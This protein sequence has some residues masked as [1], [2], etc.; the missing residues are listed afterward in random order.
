MKRI[1]RRLLAVIRREGMSRD[2]EAELRAHVEMEAESLR[3]QGMDAAAARRRAGATLGGWDATVEAVRETHGLPRTEAVL[4]E[5]RQAGR[6]LRRTPGFTASAV[7]VLA[8]G[9]GG[10]TAAYGIARAVLLEPLPY[11]DES[12]MVSVYEADSSGARRIPS[13]PTVREWAGGAGSFEAIAY[14]RGET[15]PVRSDEG[16]L[17]LLAAYATDD[18]FR[19]MRV[20][21]ALGRVF[22]EAESSAG[23]AV[24]VLSWHVWRD[25]YGGD[26]AVVGRSLSTAAGPFTVVGVMPEGVRY[27]AWADLWL[28]Q[29][30]LSAAGRAAI[31]RRDLHVDA[32]TVA[33]LSREAS[34]AQ[35]AEELRVFN[36]RAA[37][38]HPDARGWTDVVL[39][40]VRSEVLGSAGGTVWLLAGATGLLLLI[41][42]VNVAGLLVARAAARERE[43]SVR[44]ALGASRRRLAAQLLAESALL[45][46]AGGLLGTVVAAVLLGVLSTRAASALPRLETAHIDPAA[47]AFAVAASLGTALL[48]GLLPARRAGRVAPMDALRA[49]RGTAGPRT[50]RIRAGLVVAEIA[51]AAVLVVAA[52]SLGRALLERSTADLGFD[53]EGL[54]T[55]RI[56][57]PASQ[58]A[59]PEAS[60]AL[61]ERL[62]EEAARVPGVDRVA[63]VN[64]LP[65]SGT[66]MPTDVRTSRTPAPGERPAALFRTISPNYFAT[67]GIALIAGRSITDDELSSH[68]PVAVVN[69]ALAAREW[70]DGDALGQS[71]TVRR[72]AQ[73]RADFGDE[74]T[75]TVVGI[76]R[77]TRSFGPDAPEPPVVYAPYTGVVWSSLYIVAGAAPERTTASLLDG[78]RSAVRAVDPAI[79]VAGPGFSNRIRPMDDYASNLLRA[80]RL[81]TTLFGGFAVAALVL[82]TVGLFGVVAYHVVQRRREFGVRVA[83]GAP[84][85]VIV[86]L[87]AGQGIRLVAIGLAL[88]FAGA[89]AL[90]RVLRATQ[91]DLGDPRPDTFAAAA[92]IFAAATLAAC[93]VPAVRALRTAPARILREDG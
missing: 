14:V 47:L 52:T 46:A 61:Y 81:N 6:A 21:P 32:I 75:L 68:A 40:D 36:L 86:K 88:G 65:L 72:V 33:R 55:L 20:S 28:P 22:D 18:L 39:T 76:A 43:L 58:Y 42:C 79:P 37:S 51:L 90:G 60:L 31:E 64:H 66:S 11:A 63:F 30:A 16:T 54:V 25:Q 83:L 13:W 57:P 53:T 93:L 92:V 82:A 17:L 12:R 69:E 3:A 84:G 77:D 10:A 85:G 49:T 67:L 78:L 8:L 89:V 70:P 9:V 91:P 23:D 15:L 62:R 87:V 71:I 4:R 59:T 38:V 5:L 44:A 41:A 34:H 73:D 2:I 56:M 74:L 19:V 24:A 29:G 48:F 45:A 27:P 1:L 7:G 50:E 26:P 80:R 35:A